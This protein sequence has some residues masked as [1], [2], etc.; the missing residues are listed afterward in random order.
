MKIACRFAEG[1]PLATHFS[2]RLGG[3]LLEVGR[4]DTFDVAP[5]SLRY[6]F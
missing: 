6:L 4:N 1:G 3:S 2:R 5:E